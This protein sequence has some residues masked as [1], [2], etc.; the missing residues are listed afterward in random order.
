MIIEPQDN[1]QRELLA[2]YHFLMTKCYKCD[3][4]GNREEAVKFMEEA[5]HISLALA[6]IGLL[7]F[8]RNGNH[9]LS[10]RS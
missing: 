6:Q 5:K 9:Y 7:I 8:N 4:N 2:K 1:T 3:D 10:K